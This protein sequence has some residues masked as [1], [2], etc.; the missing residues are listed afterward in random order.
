MEVFS[1]KVELRQWI[2]SR[3][4]RSRILVPTMG[5]LHEG[6]TSLFDLA[7]QH[8]EDA[9][10]IATLFVNPTQFGPNEDF[11]AYPRTL[12]QDLDLCRRHGVSAVFSPT[13]DEMYAENLSLSVR[14]TALSKRLCGAS[15]PGHFDGVCLVVAK[16]FLLTQPDHAIFGEKDF[17]QLAILKRMVRDLDFPIEIEGGP[18]VREADGLALSSRNTYLSEKERNEAPELYRTLCEGAA[19]LREAKLESVAAIRE[20]M[21]ARIRRC[22]TARIDYLE[23]VDAETLE[24]DLPPDKSQWRIIAA[25]FFGK[26]RLIDNLGVLDTS[27]APSI[28]R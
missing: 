5:A 4:D 15:R 14:E 9:D 12:Q 7:V 22:S 10:V 23:V 17:Q 28:S 1:S 21:I 8:G 19:L 3:S 6:H 18:T 2:R 20:E 27:P 24:E 26:T 16:L 11:D 13:P 25:V